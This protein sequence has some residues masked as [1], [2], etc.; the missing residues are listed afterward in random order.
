MARIEAA[1]AKPLAPQPPAPPPPPAPAAIQAAASPKAPPRQITTGE[2][3]PSGPVPALPTSAPAF[4]TLSGIPADTFAPATPKPSPQVIAAFVP[5][6]A[7]LRPESSDALKQLAARRA[8]GA[9]AILGG[10]EARSDAPDAQAAALPLAWRRARAIQ[11]VLMAAGVPT[12]AM[13]VDAAALGRG[14]IARLVD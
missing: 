10:G 11:D 5:N 2:P 4:P 12:S 6:S 14:G 7:V 1:D 8:G 9:V 3:A 13:H